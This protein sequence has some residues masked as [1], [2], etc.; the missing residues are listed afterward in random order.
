MTR[1]P[2]QSV[3]WQP[4]CVCPPLTSPLRSGLFQVTNDLAQSLL[5]SVSLV[6]PLFLLA[7][8]KSQKSHKM[9]DRAGLAGLICVSICSLPP[10]QLQKI[11]SGCQRQ[12]KPESVHRELDAALYCLCSSSFFPVTGKDELARKNIIFLEKKKISLGKSAAL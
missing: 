1:P 12:W 10:G 11:N 4:K 3:W 6:F 7:W 2:L 5:V 8:Q 9:T